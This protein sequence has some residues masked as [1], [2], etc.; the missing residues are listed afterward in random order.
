MK[1]RA[2]IQKEIDGDIWEGLDEAKEPELNPGEIILSEEEISPSS[3]AESS[4]EP[5]TVVFPL[6]FHL[7]KLMLCG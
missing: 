1:V 3:E 6:F 7:R 4:C 5:P 2:L